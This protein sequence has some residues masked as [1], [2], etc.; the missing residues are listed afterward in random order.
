MDEKVFVHLNRKTSFFLKLSDQI[1][2]CVAPILHPTA[3]YI[4]K[5]TPVSHVVFDHQDFVVFNQYPINPGSESPSEFLFYFLC[6]VRH[7]TRRFALSV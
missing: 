6:Y 1:I 2:P 7:I 3:R 4:P 5:I